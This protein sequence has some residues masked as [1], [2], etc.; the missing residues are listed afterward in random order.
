MD[1]F[2]KKSLKS[3]HYTLNLIEGGVLRV[4]RNFLKDSHALQGTNYSQGRGSDEFASFGSK[5]QINGNMNKIFIPLKWESCY[6]NGTFI[7]FIFS[8]MSRILFGQK[9]LANC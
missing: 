4:L 3:T 9:I 5:D 2:V 8:A 1:W 6:L 7:S